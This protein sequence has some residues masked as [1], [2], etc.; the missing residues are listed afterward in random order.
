MSVGAGPLLAL[1]FL[2]SACAPQSTREGSGV[3]GDQSARVT[4]PKKLTIAL[5]REYDT[6]DGG[7]GAF[8][9]RDG[10]VL[11]ARASRYLR[12]RPS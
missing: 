3:G 8:L 5:Q 1:V 7:E 10:L 2:V 9:L 11:A 12:S 4:G 6:A